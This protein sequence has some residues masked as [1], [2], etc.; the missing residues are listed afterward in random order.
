MLVITIPYLNFDPYYSFLLTKINIYHKEIWRYSFYTHIIVCIPILAAGLTQFSNYILTKQTRL[1]KLNGKIYV[2]GILLLGA[3]SG[4]I[5]GFY[6]NGGLLA[7]ISFMLL[8]LL[9]FT[10]TL[11]GFIK[12]KQKDIHEHKKWLIRSYALTLSALFLRFYAMIF[13]TIF[14]IS[15]KHEYIILAWSS[16]VP[17]LILV[18]I[19]FLLNPRKD[20]IEE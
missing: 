14:H 8:S 3:P 19:F 18:E 11:M 17:N 1:H 16:W 15:G 5:M 6:G 7:Q 2:L 12:I 10:F 20:L 13:P 9:W 4:F